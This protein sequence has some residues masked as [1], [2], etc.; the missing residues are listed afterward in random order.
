LVFDSGDYIIG[1][2]KSL[3]NS[4]LVFETKYSDNDF[5]IKWGEVSQINTET[6]FLVTLTDGRKYIGNL[7]SRSLSKV[8]IHYED[9]SE[10]ECNLDEIVYLSEVQQKF[11]DRFYASIDL[12]FS[13]TKANDFRQASSRTSL[14]YLADDWNTNLK[15]NA[16][17]SSQAKTESIKRIEGA[18]NERYIFS[19]NWYSLFTLSYLSNTEQ[20]LS[21]RVN[22][23]LSI[24]HFIIRTNAVYWGLKMGFNRNF[25]KY[26]NE[27]DERSS[28]EGHFGT[29]AKFFNTGD[30]SMT[31]LFKA[32]PSITKSGRWRVDWTLDLKYDLP[33]D[34]YI[35]LGGS[36]NFDN[37]P[38]ENSSRTDYVL[39][40]GFGWE[41]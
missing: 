35:K 29:E 9:E 11:K 6:E 37:F 19:G 15:L 30:F 32:Y 3:E 2:I 38:S 16:I 1:E 26:S 17:F 18:I 25:E 5:K 12:G 22:A 27:F 7:T 28:W 34:F 21:R 4:I 23:E 14:G 13:Q 31:T 36:L 8:T 40:T 20:N 33:L 39:Q 41:W 24:G 10:I